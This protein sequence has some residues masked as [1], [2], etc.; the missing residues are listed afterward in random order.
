MRINLLPLDQQVVVIT[1]A[2]SGI[3]LVTSKKAARRGARVVLA[4]RNRRDL[5]AAVDEIREQGGRAAFSVA[6]VANPDEVERIAETAIGEFGRIDTWVNNAAASMYGRVLDLP[7]SDMRRQMDVN[8]W[9]QVYGS[10]VAVRH[11]RNHGGALI[12]V[13]SALSERAFPLQASYCAGKHALKA[14][15]DS[16]RLELEDE[17]V[18]ISV[19][20]VKPASVDTPFFD[21]ARTYLNAEPQ[22][23]PPVYAPE[24][25]AEVILTAAERPLRELVVGGAGAR[26]SLARLA[27]RLA[28]R[29]AF[30]SQVG[31]PSAGNRPDNLHTPVAFDGGERGRNWRG[32]TRESSVYTKAALHPGRALAFIAAGALAAGF[33]MRRP[34]PAGAQ[35]GSR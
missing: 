17:G 6:D 12:N 34:S 31:R 5:D 23:V 9:G 7:I 8:Y 16:F 28:G 10:I 30:D 22:P 25:V 21:K 18:P 14:F 35:E 19:T 32:H 29:W 13:G 3:G 20:L 11:M 33:A 2:S 1:G 27:P 4:A 15:T 24:V 26:S